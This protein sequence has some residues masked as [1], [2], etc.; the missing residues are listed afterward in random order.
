MQSILSWLLGL[1]D[2]ASIDAVEAPRL[3]APWAAD[4]SGPFWVFLGVA[5]AAVL[6][7]AFYT[8]AQKKGHVVTRLGLAGFRGLLLAML[9]LT[10]AE[11]VLQLVLT[12]QSP[13]VLFVLF[14]GT[15]SMG[16]RDELPPEEQS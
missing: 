14:D 4:R 1:P 5:L 16:L 13:P 6:A 15:D 7:V 2:A 8:L 10:L 3:A 11:P 12:N 9:L